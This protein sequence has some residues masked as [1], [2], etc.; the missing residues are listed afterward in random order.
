MKLYKFLVPTLMLGSVV[1]FTSCNSEEDDIFNAS[2]AER[3]DEYK[4]VYSADLTAEGGRWLMEYFPNEEERGYVFVMTFNPDGSVKV[5]GH[6]VW[7]NSSYRSDISLWQIVTDNGPVLSF[8]TYNS[9]LHEF[10]TPEDIVGDNQPKDPDTGE[11]IDEQGT[12][13]GG[14]YEFV[15]LGLSEDGKTMHLAGKKTLHDIY[16]HRLDASVDEVELLSSYFAASKG[17][18][19]VLF[20]DAILTDTESGEQFVVSGGEDGIFDFW[21]KDGD[22]VVQ[23]VSMNALIGPDAIRLRKPLAVEC[24]NETDSIVVENLIH[25]Q[26]GTYLCTDNNKNLVLD[27]CGLD[28]IFMINTF[29]WKLSSSSD[30]GGKFAALYNQIT[31]ETLSSYKVAFQGLDFIY[32]EGKFLLK[33]NMRGTTAKAYIYGNVDSGSE[34][35]SL[36]LFYDKTDANSNGRNRLNRIPALGEF[37]DFVSSTEY[38]VEVDAS[39]WFA[40]KRMRLVSKS[41]PEDWFIVTWFNNK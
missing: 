26:D 41:N 29:G 16:M 34:K 39:E 3:L 33:F 21:P 6:N 11:E 15:I 32:D 24:A 35:N 4:K 25:Q 7:M 19:D 1:G 17:A 27:N 40:P 30:V 10:S 13:H 9:V 28:N 5:S 37:V 38:K 22:P 18:F 23:T 12:G 2:A 36:K 31:A 14:D 8:N 20:P